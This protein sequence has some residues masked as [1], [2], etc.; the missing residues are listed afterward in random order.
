MFVISTILID[1]LRRPTQLTFDDQRRRSGRGDPVPGA[2]GNGPGRK[3]IVHHIRRQPFRKNSACLVTV[4]V[5]DEIPKLRVKRF[6]RDF[7]RSL[8]KACDQGSFRVIHYSIQQTHLHFVV[9]AK[10]KR[11]LG[12][13]MKSIS[14]RIARAVNRVFGRKGPVLLGRY[15]VRVMGTPREV[16][17]GLRYVLLNAR[18]HWAERNRGKA[19]APRLDEGSSMRW[20]DG[21]KRTPWEDPLPDVPEVARARYWITTRG[22]RRYGL[23]DPADVPGL[24]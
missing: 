12:V 23:L 18:K 11:A 1:M 20:F 13:G 21:W 22:W 19:R 4:R 6:V 14:T 15:H 3:G 7:R 17:N 9:E 8:R 2:A 10:D 5:R 16:R 24:V